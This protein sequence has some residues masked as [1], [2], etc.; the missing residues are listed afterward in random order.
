MQYRDGA[1]G[2]SFELPDGWRRD[3]HNIT[4]TFSWP[5]GGPSAS[6]EVIQLMIGDVLPRYVDPVKREKFLIE[7]GV[8]VLLLTSVARAA[9]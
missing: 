8:T 7:P 4:T 5:N 3:E 9:C 2:F 1:V 6:S